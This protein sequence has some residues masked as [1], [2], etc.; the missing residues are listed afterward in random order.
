MSDIVQ[1]IFNGLTDSLYQFLSFPAVNV[2]DT[3]LHILALSSFGVIYCYR[4]IY[5]LCLNTFLSYYHN[6]KS[7]EWFSFECRKVVFLFE[8]HLLQHLL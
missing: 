1:S 5:L 7:I 2:A 6:Y 4:S 3:R 8:Q